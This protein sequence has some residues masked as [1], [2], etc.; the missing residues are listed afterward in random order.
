MALALPYPDLDFVPLDILTAEE[1]NQIVANYT[2]VAGQFPITS[3]NID[4]MTLE[5]STTEQRVGTWINGKPVY[6]KVCSGTI[7]SS[8]QFFAN[9]TLLS[10]V[11][12]IIGQTG[13]LNVDGTQYI[14]PWV[15]RDGT[16]HTFTELFRVLR[17]SAGNVILQVWSKTA[18]NVEC[19]YD[20]IL[21]Y[22]KT[23]D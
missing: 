9:T 11:E 7:T 4:W 16:T 5:Y 12:T 6:R 1:M 10:G 22:T 2:H 13:N 15:N 18:P 20:L 17:Q 21:T 19:N 3:D 8:D 23:S 14:L